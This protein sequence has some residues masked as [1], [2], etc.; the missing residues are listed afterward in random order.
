MFKHYDNGNGYEFCS[1]REGWG[2]RKTTDRAEVTCKNCLKRLAAAE[3][4]KEAMQSVG[5]IGPLVT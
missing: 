3:Q 4:R 1:G 2:R 5:Q